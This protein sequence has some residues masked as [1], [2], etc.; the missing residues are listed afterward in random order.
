MSSSKPQLQ[1]E[2]TAIELFEREL[3]GARR[4]D[5]ASAFVTRSGI[6]LLAGL[7]HLPSMRLV[8]RANHGVTD[9]EAVEM[10]A[11]QLGAKVR[12]VVGAEAAR[13][14]PKLYL[15][16]RQEQ[17]VVL[18]GSGNLTAGGLRDNVE[19][20]ELHTLRPSTPEAL[21]HEKRFNELWEKGEPL[22]DLRS[23]G[24]WEEWTEAYRRRRAL[25][26]PED[27]ID[28]H[29]DAVARAIPAPTQTMAAAGPT[30]GSMS[31]E[32]IVGALERWSPSL[33]HRRAWAGLLADAIEEVHDHAPSSWVL[34]AV[35]RSQ[36]DGLA[37][38]QLMLSNSH[39]VR[40]RDDGSLIAGVSDENVIAEVLRQWPRVERD[41]RGPHGVPDL[42]V[43][44]EDVAGAVPLLRSAALEQVR[45]RRATR[46]SI[47][48]GA[49]SE[50]A[51]KEVERVVGRRLPRPE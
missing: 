9:P 1:P 12:L 47:R 4:F 51:V 29:L 3:P 31:A 39:L 34:L 48:R 35:D 15:V 17:L 40:L 43:A 7:L 25:R 8:C 13:F 37:R 5:A 33:D 42:V 21:D 41:P 38:F 45:S 44:A 10:A 14:H 46:P 24:F 50:P 32:A 6:E 18:S 28:A 30:R 2:F 16:E 11:T 19:Q 20:F 49:H 36:F 22:E 26:E 27:E 23:T